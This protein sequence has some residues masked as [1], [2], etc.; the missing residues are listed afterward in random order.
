MDWRIPELSDLDVLQECSLNNEFFANNYGAVNS[1]LYE[2]KFRSQISIEDGWI[3]ERFHEGENLCFS[4]PH[5][6]KGD[7]SD[8]KEAVLKLKEDAF[9]SDVSIRFLN[10]SLDEKNILAE[11]FPSAKII[12]MPESGDYIYRTE[13]LSKLPGKKLGR[14]RNHINQ[15]KA[16]HPDC[17]F[18]RLDSE[19]IRAVCEL[20][21]KWLSENQSDSSSGDL[22]SDLE[23]ERKIIFF[24]VE[25]FEC[26]SKSCGMSGGILFVSETPVA[27]CISS[28][29]SRSVTDIHFEKCISDFARDGGYAVI[30]NEF[31][32]IAGTEFLNREEDLGIEGLR[33]AKLSYYPEKVLEK[34]LVEIN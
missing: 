6:I 24:A 18:E 4:F 26:L 33:K 29:L 21:N 32:K 17:R 8:V 20:E 19:N 5:N 11:M 28:I 2:K 10:I 12:S 9:M 22:L 15:F 16:K 31:S 14:K 1:I 3:F 30:N 25:N 7:V 13:N 23:I 27:F 34:F